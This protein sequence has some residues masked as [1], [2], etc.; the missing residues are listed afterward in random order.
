[1]KKGGSH[2][3]LKSYKEISHL[4]SL[5]NQESHFFVPFFIL[6]RRSLNKVCS[7][8]L[9]VWSSVHFP[10]SSSSWRA[11][12][13]RRHPLPGS[14][15]GALRPTPWPPPPPP[16]CRPRCKSRNNNIRKKTTTMRR[17]MQSE[18]RKKIIMFAL[19]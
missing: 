11:I 1:M 17:T 19:F 12:A 16:R 15:V 7:C 14:E 9:Q 6:R 2:P 13:E 4:L 3:I 10:S 18:T 8:S 5:T